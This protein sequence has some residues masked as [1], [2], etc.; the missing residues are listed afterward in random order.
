MSQSQGIVGL[1]TQLKMGNAASPEVFTLIPE[2]K[3]FDGPEITPEFADFT[4]QQST[5]GFRERKPTFKSSGA[6]TFK[7]NRVKADTQQNALIT[8]A[9]AVPV[10]L[11]NFQLVYPDA[12]TITFSAYPSIKWTGP[13]AGPKEL[14]VTLSLQGAFVQS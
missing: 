4:H 3:D 6:I 2:C 1:D 12:E 10:T 7:M 8:A 11:K 13:M 5:S 14:S 9:Q